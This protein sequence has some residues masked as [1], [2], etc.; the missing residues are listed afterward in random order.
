VALA[1]ILAS[2]ASAG[3]SL[4][5][6]T[7]PPEELAGTITWALTRAV[8]D[9]VNGPMESTTT[10]VTMDVIL[11]VSR[12]RAGVTLFQARE[13]N[14]TAQG[15]G[16]AKE[17]A[18]ACT[19]DRDTSVDLR[20][21]FAANNVV[22]MIHTDTA[23]RGILN[24]SL[25]KGDGSVTAKTRYC[26]GSEVSQNR[27]YFWA[28]SDAAVDVVAHRAKNGSLE[29]LVAK[30]QVAPCGANATCTRTASGVLRPVRQNS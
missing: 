8:E 9:P 7:T 20:G 21:T 13:G 15:T 19:I 28:I 4:A 17:R 29:F 30:E 12:S 10:T 27:T 14:W 24:F 5:G 11:R 22:T 18:G 25:S 23:G 2:G 1:A 3:C 16:A 26:D 6:A